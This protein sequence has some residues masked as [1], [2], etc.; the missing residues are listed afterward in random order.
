MKLFNVFVAFLF[1]ALPAAAQQG[2][3]GKVLLRSGNQ[4]PAPGEPVA[5]QPVRRRVV[6]FALTGQHEATF[7]DGLF[8]QITTQKVAET[9][10]RRNGR[11]KIRL[12]PGRYSVLVQEPDGLYANL[13]DAEM[14]IHPVTV[15]AGK[16]TEV[17]IQI[18]RN[19]AD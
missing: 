12:P 10:S 1:M 3:T 14:H 7:R 4:M 9:T 15:A 19:T 16:F 18:S 11:F 6:I 2:I 8:H 17:R 5:E 13:W